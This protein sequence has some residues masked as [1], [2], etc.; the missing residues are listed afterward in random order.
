MAGQ[1]NSRLGNAKRIEIE[2]TIKQL[3]DAILDATPYDNWS[4][5]NLPKRESGAWTA[6]APKGLGA[7]ISAHHRDM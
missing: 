4:V 1:N 6:G 2:K 5:G 3:E 7:I